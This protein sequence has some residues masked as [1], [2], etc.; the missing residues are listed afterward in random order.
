V[1]S[2]DTILLQDANGQ[3]VLTYDKLHVFDA[4]GQ[5]IPAR[6][7][8]LSQEN[9]TQKLHIIVDESEAVYPLTIDPT[10]QQAYLKA[11]N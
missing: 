11:S 3:T 4:N 5:T 1:L 7:S 2:G 6:F 9:S 8:L 10:M